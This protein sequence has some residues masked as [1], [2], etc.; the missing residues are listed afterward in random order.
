M[1][2]GVGAGLLISAVW[3]FAAWDVALALTLVFVGLTVA[4]TL[5]APGWRPFG[6]AMVVAAAVTGGALVLVVV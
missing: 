4:V 1:A 3:A 6:L 5:G 2:V